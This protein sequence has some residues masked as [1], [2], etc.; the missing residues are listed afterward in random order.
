[1]KRVLRR[2]RKRASSVL[3]PSEAEVT[4]SRERLP[5][6]DPHDL[7]SLVNDARSASPQGDTDAAFITALR[8][9]NNQQ[10]SELLRALNVDRSRPDVWQRAFIRLAF[11]Y[12][13]M[14]HLEWR[15]RISK[16][17]RGY[18]VIRTRVET[19][20]GNERIKSKGTQ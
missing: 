8:E 5:Q 11:I 16:E 7:R 14:G 20:G 3:W 12:H 2:K 17:E 10:I 19:L 4:A 6:F 15:R 18:V 9:R 13:G 1:M